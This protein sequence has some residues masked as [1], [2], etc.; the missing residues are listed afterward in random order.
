MII[1]MIDRNNIKNMTQILSYFTI[2]KNSDIPHELFFIF[3]KM[4]KEFSIVKEKYNENFLKIS[5]I[6]C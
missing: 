6:S 2:N 5:F 4:E 1:K 3:S